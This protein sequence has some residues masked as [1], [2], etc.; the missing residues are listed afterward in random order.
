MTSVL[1]ESC[2]EYLH[3]G[4]VEYLFD[5]HGLSSSSSPAETK[6][7][8]SSVAAKLESIGFHV[9]ERLA[10]RACKDQPWFLEELD[11]IKF[12]CRE[13]WSSVFKGQV[14]KLQ[15]NY[16]DIYVLHDFNFRWFQRIS[17]VSNSS[18]VAAPYTSLA[19]GI[20]R[21]ALAN[22]GMSATVHAEYQHKFPA[23]SFRIVNVEAKRPRAIAPP[24]VSM[25]TG[26][27][28]PTGDADKH[29][30]GQA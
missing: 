22:L 3:I 25:L 9:G 27:N 13:F 4:L 12:F 7:I 20:I 28:S 29:S 10:E 17:S 2:F 24:T 6:A 18:E 21:G 15:T 1:A 5:L 30:F 11:I 8:L 26:P 14:D 19:C 23:C 16:K